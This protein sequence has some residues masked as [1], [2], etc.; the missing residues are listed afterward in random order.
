MQGFISKNYEYIKTKIDIDSIIDFWV[1]ETYFTNNDIVNARFYTHPSINGGRMRGIL[2]DFDWAMYNYSK[3]Y[4]EFSTSATP[5]SR[6]QISTVVLRNLMKNEEFK[7]RYVERLAY[8]M[9][10]TFTEEKVLARINEMHDKLKVDLKKDFK[11]WNLDFSKWEGNVEDLRK[12]AR[13]RGGYIINNIEDDFKATRKLMS[14]M[15]EGH[16]YYLAVGKHASIVKQVNG[17]FYYLELQSDI[18]N[19]WKPMGNR[20]QLCRT[21][22]TQRTC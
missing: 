15:R 22:G 5:M 10:N 18:Q 21:S 17:E 6:L 2:Y 8:H 14:V 4:Y 13:L 11:R 1:T 19:G 12:Y 7:K 3:N 16:E 9:K 20:D